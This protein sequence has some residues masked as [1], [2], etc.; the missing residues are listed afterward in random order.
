MKNRSLF[1]IKTLSYA[2][3]HV[4]RKRKLFIW[5]N[6]SASN[7]KVFI[8]TRLLF[9]SI[10]CLANS[11]RWRLVGFY[12][13]GR[14]KSRSFSR[15]RF[16]FS[17]SA[18]PPRFAFLS[19]RGKILRTGRESEMHKV[20]PKESAYLLVW[21]DCQIEVMFTTDLCGKRIELFSSRL[22]FVST[23]KV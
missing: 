9:Y 12:E 11:I 22:L 10:F 20:V 17:T 8:H 14:E 7:K 6:T 16:S 15:L 4:R 19:F 2:I 5:I 1:A 23:K 21:T 13:R 3:K 18:V